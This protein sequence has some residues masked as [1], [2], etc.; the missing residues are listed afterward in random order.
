MTPGQPLKESE[1]VVDIPKAFAHDLH[2][3]R[4]SDTNWNFDV[5]IRDHAAFIRRIVRY[6][7][8][9]NNWGMISDEDD[10][11]QEA[12]IRI[13]RY[14]RQWNPT[15]YPDVTLERYVM[16][17]V[18]A[19][20]SKIPRRETNK[21]H[22]AE[23]PMF[24]LQR[25]EHGG[26]NDSNSHKY[27]LESRISTFGAYSSQYIV[28]RDEERAMAIHRAVLR[29]RERPMIYRL[30]L[31]A[32]VEEGTTLDAT[33]RLVSEKK[34]RS[35]L[36]VRGLAEKLHAETLPELQQYLREALAEEGVEV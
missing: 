25:I 8:R 23:Q 10:L 18:G 12:C 4:L 15:K 31:E 30:L 21:K 36:P 17:N 11:F 32:L 28:N 9:C 33:R 35:A 7:M 5:L 6:A 2:A 29:L 20:L 3:A 19:D 13:V 16:Y 34:I 22:R 1:T 24:N 14:V 27:T 26:G